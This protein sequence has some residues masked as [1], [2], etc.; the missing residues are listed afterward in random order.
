MNQ[1]VDLPSIEM[2]QKYI[3]EFDND[4]E[5][6]TAEDVLSYLFFKY[7]T[8]Q[9]LG[10]ILIKVQVL[11]TLY[12]TN[13]YAIRK[14]AKSILDKNIDAKLQLGLPELVGEIAP[15]YLENSKKRRNYSFAS[16]YC[17]WH[18]PETFPIYDN[19]VEQ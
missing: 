14:V 6:V 11:N 17:H 16:K 18:R 3:N 19:Y 10:V 2:A 7:P 1:I 5:L 15:I 9:E 4:K 13:I 12:N 8:N